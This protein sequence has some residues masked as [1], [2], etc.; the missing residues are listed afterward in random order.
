MIIRFLLVF[1]LSTAS[2]WCARPVYAQET[3][4]AEQGA[5]T[6]VWVSVFSSRKVLYSKEA[7]LELIA[8]CKRLGINEIYLQVFQ[9]GRAYYD[10]HMMDAAKY[11][12]MYQSAGID[13]VDF[14]LQEAHKDNIRVFAWI[15]LLSL[16]QNAQADII[17][18]FGRDVL[19]RDQYGRPSGHKNQNVSDEYYLREDQ[20][21]LE[22]GDSRVAKFLV[23]AVSEVVKRYPS[24]AGVHLDYIRYPMT[25]PFTPGSRFSRYGLHYG[26]GRKN[27][28]RFKD[29]SGRDP[30]KGLSGDRDFEAWDGWRRQ[31]VTNLVSQISRAVKQI[32]PQMLVSAAVIPYSERAYASMFQDWP[33]WLEEKDVD[34]VVLM[35]YAKDTR[36]IK[37]TVRSALAHRS[38]GKVYAGVGLFQMK[39]DPSIIAGQI[40]MLREIKP[41]GIVFFAYDDLVPEV[42]VVLNDALAKEQI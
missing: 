1:F 21:F 27:V 26:Y 4:V 14:L 24:F 38:Q 29:S 33:L 25:V 40:G 20:L 23:D 39:D 10:T 31:Q 37:E 42:A 18:K 28:E 7:V 11:R 3:V 36:L 6:G 17:G 32:S 2:L 5:A 19:T 41:D 8:A 12:Q 22:P 9:S 30:L 13:P 16:G 34:Y 15:N 35:S